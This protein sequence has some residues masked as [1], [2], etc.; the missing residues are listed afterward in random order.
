MFKD[1]NSGELISVKLDTLD[2][3]YAVFEDR[4]VKYNKEKFLDEYFISRGKTPIY[5]K[6]AKR[7]E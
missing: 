2:T 3:I 4:S 1:K 5:N 7:A 6:Y